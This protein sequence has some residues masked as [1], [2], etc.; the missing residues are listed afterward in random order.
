MAQ[1]QP[2]ADER[3]AVIDS[4]LETVVVKFMADNADVARAD[5]LKLITKRAMR[6]SSQS[7][8]RGDRRLRPSRSRPRRQYRNEMRRRWSL[9]RCPALRRAPIDAWGLAAPSPIGGAP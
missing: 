7:L 4:Y 5:V 9:L 8:Q 6:R 1:R 2:T 3:N